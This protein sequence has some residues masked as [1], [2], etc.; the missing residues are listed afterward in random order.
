MTD[1][2]RAAWL[3]DRQTGIGGTDAAAIAGVGFATPEQ[4]YADKLATQPADREPTERMRLGTYLEPFV[5]RR[6]AEAV[7]LPVEVPLRPRVVRH[8][9]AP[10]RLCSPDAVLHRDARHAR[11]LEFKCVFGPPGGEWGEPGTDQIPDGYLVQVQ[12]SLDV[13]RAAGAV[14]E[15]A[16]DVAVL[17]VGFELRVYRVSLNPDLLG[18]LVDL[19]REF[20]Q[21][22]ESR[23]GI[24]GWDP[25]LRSELANR[26]AAIR[27]DTA[28][29]L[30]P[31]ALQLVEDYEDAKIRERGY[32]DVADQHKKNLLRLLGTAEEG[33]LPDGRRVRQKVIQRAGYSVQPCTC[34]DFRVLKP[35]GKRDQQ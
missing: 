26:L 11:L 30:G 10:W 32:R 29:E 19:E 3:K 15:D 4:V 7:G 25:P 34:V 14:T 16:A 20:W 5:A 12:H 24:D 27:P 6:Y 2:G 31:D 21:R 18:P 9:A 13:C 8:P 22:V 35:R 17:F 28:V 23:A 1:T 33:R